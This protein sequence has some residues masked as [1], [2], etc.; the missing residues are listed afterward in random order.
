[1]P[2]LPPWFRQSLK[3]DAQY[4]EV[5][6][7]V[8][9]LRL[10]TVCQ[11]ARCPNRTECW[12]AGTATVLLLG[13]TCT[14]NCR[15]CAVKH[16]RPQPADSDEPRRVAE[17]VARLALRHVVLTSV[18]RDDLPDGGASTFAETIRQVRAARPQATI[19]VLTPDFLGM[20]PAL[21]LVLAASPNVFNHNLETVR[22]LQEQVRP[23]AAYDRSLGVLR[24]ASEWRPALKVKSGLM[25]GMGE[26]DAERIETLRDLF[27][28]GCRWLTLGQYLPPGRDA[29]P[30][31]DFVS[32][33]EFERL[34]AAARQIGFEDVAAGPRVRSS[35]QAERMGRPAP[36]A[37][38]GTGN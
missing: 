15:F 17:A 1:M 2:R 20:T 28:A 6:D 10:N 38:P 25:L 21:D 27:A 24:H 19:E 34:A 22:R 13:D 31:H 8:S 11:S 37:A 18:T 3:T 16:G 26:T 23:Q 7:L 35:Y 4:S 9:G 36:R 33:S 29:W 32:P 12:N 14:R 30:V 5:Y